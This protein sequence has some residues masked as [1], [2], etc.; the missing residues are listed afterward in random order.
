MIDYLAL[1]KAKM[2]VKLDN[3]IAVPPGWLPPLQRV[4]Y[5]NP[6]LGLLGMAAGWT[7]NKGLTRY[8]VQPSSHIGGVGM[9]RIRPFRDHPDLGGSGRFGFT[10]WQHSHDDIERGW[11]T[12][13]IEAVQ[14]DLIPEEP[15]HS[16]TL[17][18]RVRKWAREWP[19]YQD[20]RLWAWMKQRVPA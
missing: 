18:Y 17:E 4:M 7:G 19:P 8:T 6:H 9:M 2:F 11:I 5:A 12:P 15:W 1:T 14:L 13:D 20:P 10:E 3:D 16:L